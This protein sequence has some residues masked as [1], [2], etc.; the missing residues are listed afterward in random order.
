MILFHQTHDF[1]FR[2]SQRIY[3]SVIRC[4][5]PSPLRADA[6]C[7]ARNCRRSNLSLISI[8]PCPWNNRVWAVY[9]FGTYQKIATYPNLNRRITT[10]VCKLYHHRAIKRNARSSGSKLSVKKEQSSEE[11]NRTLS[12][13]LSLYLLKSISNIFRSK[14]ESHMNFRMASQ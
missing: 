12:S 6:L 5:R 14:P 8:C 10:I 2:R 7:S 4:S 11:T 1:S 3:G 9:R 13:S